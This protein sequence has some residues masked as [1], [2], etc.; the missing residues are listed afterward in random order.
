MHTRSHLNAF[1]LLLLMGGARA[2]EGQVRPELAKRYF[3]E[4]T[5]ALRARRGPALG[6]ITLWPDGDC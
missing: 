5:E 1:L 4:A 3:D 6:A 2:A